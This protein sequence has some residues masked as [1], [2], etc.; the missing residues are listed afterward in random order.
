[1]VPLLVTHLVLV[2]FFLSQARAALTRA[3]CSALLNVHLFPSHTLANPSSSITT[4]VGALMHQSPLLANSLILSK[5]STKKLVSG[6]RSLGM[7]W[8][9]TLT[10]SLSISPSAWLLP[11]PPSSPSN[12]Q[13]HYHFP[14]HPVP[15]PSLPPPPPHHSN[16]PP[17]HIHPIAVR[18]LTA[19]SL[20]KWSLLVVLT[21]T[22]HTWLLSGRLQFRTG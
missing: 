8:R 6:T 7:M 16:S 1:M 18:L 2:G 10:T 3:R 22:R 14:S 15:S 12:F 5:L 19:M 20:L 17:A 21:V 11:V 9:L 13:S 4:V